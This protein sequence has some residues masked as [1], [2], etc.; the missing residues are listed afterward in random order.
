[1]KKVMGDLMTVSINKF[2]Y[3]G[4]HKKVHEVIECH[5]AVH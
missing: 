1:M 5:L 4:L 3:M 2:L